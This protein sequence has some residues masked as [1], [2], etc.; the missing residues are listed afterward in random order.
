M[1]IASLT[2]WVAP[3]GAQGNPPVVV[4]EVEA[5]EP[6]EALPLFGG[7][8]WM[9]MFVTQS[10][11]E[12]NLDELVADNPLIVPQ[13]PAQIEVNW[14]VI[15]AEPVNAGGDHRRSRKRHQGNLEPS[16]R[17]VVRR[18][19]LYDF[20]GAYDPV[21]HEAHCADLTCTTPS[22]AELGDLISAQ[23]TAVNVQPDSVTVLT[24]GRGTVASADTLISCG[25]TCVSP[26]L[27][28]T[29]VKL[30][31]RAASGNVFRGWTGAC[32]GTHPTCTVA[33]VGHVEAT[34]TFDRAL[35]AKR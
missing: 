9:K 13:D 28:G 10:R 3:P 17:S 12:V 5:P 27:A 4:V 19:E 21:T 35:A 24:A 7:A 16:T 34:A 22:A 15:Q 20:T 23:M 18:I 8:Q 26:Y 14:D 25:H 11:R 29:A 30:T 33:V 6:A 32:A 2:Y 1:A 31:A